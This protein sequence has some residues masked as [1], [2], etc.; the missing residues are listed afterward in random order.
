MSDELG[1]YLTV[2]LG[3][4]KLRRIGKWARRDERRRT[5][6]DRQPQPL[7]VYIN[8]DIATVAYAL[9]GFVKRG[10]YKNIT[11][12]ADHEIGAAEIFRF[13]TTPALPEGAWTVQ[14]ESSL[15][16]SNPVSGPGAARE[17]TSPASPT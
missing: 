11:P 5:G 17:V 13:V 16:V 10:Q 1:V 3:M 15:S 6:I 4:C 2:R 7:T 9:P 14:I 8:P 12:I